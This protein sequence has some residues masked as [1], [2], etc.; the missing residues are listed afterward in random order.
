MPRTLAAFLATA[1]SLAGFAALI[2]GVSWF[3][4]STSFVWVVNHRP[5]GPNL[6]V[7]ISLATMYFI[8]FFVIIPGS[9][10]RKRS[11]DEIDP[12]E[13]IKPAPRLWM[14]SLQPPEE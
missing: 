12:S 4:H 14:R 10:G 2:A 3:M 7:A 5:S 8:F 6:S 9:Q 13:A 1:I 11:A